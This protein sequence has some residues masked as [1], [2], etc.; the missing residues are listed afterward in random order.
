MLSKT[1]SLRWVKMISF[2]QL[3]FIITRCFSLNAITRFTTKSFWL[4][5]NASSSDVRNLKA[6]LFQF[7]FLL[8]IEVW[9]ILT[10]NTFWLVVKLVKSRN[11]LNLTSLFS[12]AR[13]KLIKKSM[14]WFVNLITNYLT[15]IMIALSIKN[16][17]F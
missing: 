17:F 6:A 13:T 2:I 14:F 12:I 8:I 9:S 4:L 3:F 10:L 15:V 5:L 7:R 11:C 16:R 1:F